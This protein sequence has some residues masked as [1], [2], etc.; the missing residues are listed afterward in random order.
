MAIVNGEPELSAKPLDLSDTKITNDLWDLRQSCWTTSAV[1]PTA[2]QISEQICTTISEWDSF[3]NTQSFFLS[4]HNELRA[5]FAV[6]AR[7]FEL[8]HEG[9]VRHE[10]MEDVSSITTRSSSSSPDSEHDCHA[11]LEKGVLTFTCEPD[12]HLGPNLLAE[13]SSR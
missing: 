6:M 1:R 11:R 13:R 7:L 9:R 2:R 8:R 3:K 5:T 12:A 4:W 10:K